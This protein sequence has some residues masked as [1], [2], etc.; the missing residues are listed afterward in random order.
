MS[1]LARHL[2]HRLGKELDQRRVVVWYD[3]RR[4]WQPWVERL[5][6]GTLPEK[7]IAMAAT[8]DGQKANVVVF[9]GSYYEV[10]SI[11]EPLT[12]GERPE[13]LVVYLPG[14]KPLEKLTPLREIECIGGDKEPFQRDLSLTARDAFHAAGLSDS[15]IDEILNRSGISFEYLD[16]IAV[17]GEGGASPLAPVFG[18]SRE[19]DV[20]PAFLAGPARR[21]EAAKRGLLKDIA[22]LALRSCGLPLKATTDPEQMAVELQRLLLITEMRGDLEG[23]ESVA[24]SQIAK[25]QTPAQ[26]ELVRKA[27]D[28][29]RREYPEA[30]EQIADLV[31]RELGLAQ[32]EIDPLRLGRIDT[33]RFE[34][35]RLLEACDRLLAEGKASEALGIARQRAMSFWTSIE[36]HSVRHATWRACED[37]AELS[38]ALD[39]VEKELKAALRDS[40]SWVEAYTRAGGW[41]RIDQRFR[42]ARYRMTTTYDDSELDRAAERV[43]ARYDAVLERIATGFLESLKQSGWQV[44]SLTQQ[45]QIYEREVERRPKPVAYILADAM[46]YEMGATLA[47]LLKAAGADA[48]RLEPAIAMAPTITDVGMAALL[49][50]AERS[51]TIAPTLKG[52][53]GVIEKKSLGGSA[54][55]MDHAKASVPG[56]VEMT[57]DRLLHELTPV[58]VEKA[59][60]GAPVVVVRSQ[61]IDGTGESLPDGVARRV[62]GT[63]L[64]EIRKAVL[65]L[66]GAGIEHFV[67]TA[68]HGHLFGARRGDEMKIDPPEAGQQVDLHRRCWIGRGGS[69]PSACLRLSAADL[70][71][72]GT[73][74]EMI[75]PRGTGVFKAGGS[76]AFHH[77]GFSLQELVVP[78]LSFELKGRAKGRSRTGGD[79]VVLEGVPKEV[80]NLIFSLTIRR[81]DLALEPLKI[82]LIAEGKVGERSL[83]V[84]QAAFAT[85]GWD[86]GARA[87]ML[88]DTEPV[89]VGIQIDDESVTELRVLVVQ[90]G[91]DRTLKDTQPIPVRITR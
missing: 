69:T 14:E 77:G 24:L 33:F 35:R 22:D 75:V 44:K 52:I 78:V 65:R 54:A 16:A 6:G 3:E 1:F 26:V 86:A 20:I 90:V 7:A 23:Q 73:D 37:L 80:T 32:L 36:R 83:T 74:L 9:A 12:G 89:S 61:E 51:F 72:Q 64:E 76:L 55:R 19:L 81:T 42:E 84:G 57:L 31:E 39:E 45:T 34:E 63:V 71:Y 70:G 11:C 46:R 68:D 10:A 79:L 8:V 30:Y 60:R 56:L 50:G 38:L 25:P 40:K 87:L 5:L 82:R 27:C 48:L 53:A 15:K 58:Q 2:E 49:P 85:K 4:E 28:R 17:E 47:G 67:I 21:T 59:A 91:T 13:P 18:S 66:A 62:M 43:F 88:E 29:L 41:Y